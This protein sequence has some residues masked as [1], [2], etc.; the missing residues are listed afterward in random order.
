MRYHGTMKP[1]DPASL[2]WGYTRAF[3]VARTRD[4]RP[5][6]SAEM[7]K[8]ISFLPASMPQDRRLEVFDGLA[9]KVLAD[10]ALASRVYQAKMAMQPLAIAPD[11]IALMFYCEQGDKQLVLPALRRLARSHRAPLLQSGDLKARD[12]YLGGWAFKTD[13]QTREELRRGAHDAQVSLM[14]E[15]LDLASPGAARR[16]P[17]P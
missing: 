15:L 4:S 1:V 17:R 5:S 9:S 13:A 12:G 10:P 6:P 11:D 2:E 8:W 14:M 3:R 16:S 7:G